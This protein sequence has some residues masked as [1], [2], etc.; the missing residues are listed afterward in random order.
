MADSFV[1]LHVHTEYSML[2][3]AAKLKPL[4]KEAGRLGMPAVAMTDHGNMFGAYEF[5]QQSK[6][7]GVTPIIGIEAYV[8]PE[9]R[10]HKKRVFWGRASGSD[11]AS[12]EGGKDISGGGRYLHMTMLARNATGLRNLFKMSSLASVEGYYMKPRMDLDLM[13]ENSEG[14]IVSTGCPSGGVQTRLRLGQEKEAIEYAAG[15]QDIFGKEN[16]FLELMDHGVPI[17]KE[18]RD[19]LLKVGRELK[20]PPLVTNDSHYVYESQADAHDA[21]LAVGVGKNLDDPTRF[22]FNGSGYYLKTADEMRGLLTFDQWEE[23]CKNTLLIAERVEPG[24]YDEVFAHRDLMPVF[25]VPEG[26]TQSSWLAKEVERLLPT[27]YPNGAGADVR[28]RVEFELGIINTMG[29]PAYFLVVADICQYARKT[30]IALGPGRGSAAGS[31]IAYVLGITD[32]DPLEHGLLFERFLNPERVSMPDVDLDFDERRRGEMIEYVTRLYGSERVAQILTFG[33]IKAKAAVKDSTRILGMPYSVGDQIT[34]AFPAAVGGKEIPLD[35]VFN[36]EHERYAE[37]TELRNL[38]DNDPQVAKVMETARGIEGLTRGTGVHAAGVILSKEPLLDVIPLHMRDADGAII[39]GF[40][41]PQCEEMGLLKMDFLGL[42][43]LTI[44][45]DAVKSIKEAEGIDIDLSKLP[46]DDKKTYQLL[47]RGDTL[48]VFQLDGGAMRNLLKRMQPKKFGDIAAV[49]ALYRPGPMAANAHN[50]YA[51]RSNGR[52]D[53][54]AIHPELKDALDPILGETFHL[55]VYQEQ[56]MAIAQQLAGY[57]LGG[58]DLMRRAMGKKKKEALEAEEAKFFPGAMERGFSEEA[59]RTLW[60]VMLPFSGY[61]FNKSHAAGYALVS[62]WTAYLKANHPA[63]YMAALLT[64]VSDD[65]DKMAVYLAECRS[66]GIKVL[67]PDVNESGLRFTPVG[68][69]IR[70]GMGAVRNVGAN[71]VNSIIKSRTEKGNYT[72][73]TDFLSKIELAACN[74]R[75]IESLVKSGA[76]DSLGQ[77]RREL[78]RHHEIAVDGMISSKKQ[79]AHGQFDLF[80]GA[81]EG[82]DSTPIGLNI[83]WGDEEWDRKTK[84]AFEREM[85]GLYVSS[86]P[87][88]GAERVLARSRDTSIAQIVAG[89]MGRERN[90]LRIA[91]LISKVEKRVNKAGN[92]WAIATVEDLDASMEVLF[93]PKTFPL[94]V[95]ALIEDTA[96]TVK[97]RLNDRDGTWSMFA[98]DMSI[99]DISHITEGEPPVLLTVDEQRLTRELVEELR[100][101]LSSH[102]G[103]TPVRIRVDN[104]V[105]SKVFAVDRYS[106]RISPEFNGEMK[107]LLGAYAVDY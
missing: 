94:Y 60:D 62:Y 40:P 47:Q 69:D 79:E 101:V 9:S 26:E 5:Y 65:K 14:I 56:I 96:V 24:A 73:F 38:V 52:Q 29:F 36:T 4:F 50:D 71:V 100:Q 10:F 34:K 80:G 98:S 23:G 68:K 95:D 91:G 43:N 99:L 63:A 35:A 30:G 67:P 39:T 54:T 16:V 11:D 12:A 41:Y 49:N 3:G 1:H 2:D 81:D 72:S 21:L 89:E 18:V 20:I 74:K 75:V 27:R 105:R 97:G 32:L 83:N 45:D 31:M 70:F 8:A 15:L 13:S 7:S 82:G 57:T 107:S 6:G 61:A 44:M 90:E 37:T 46:L 51:D 55:I 33:T 78:Y 104:P 64:S 48:G 59:I 42:R 19:G 53:I 25:P 85:L 93:F 17:E 106:V 77:P 86:H 76:F 88:A 58:A 66:Q 92:Q 87:L 28:E 84:L 22:R 102:K 103:D